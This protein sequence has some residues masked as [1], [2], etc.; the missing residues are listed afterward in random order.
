M[1][2]MLRRAQTTGQQSRWS[3]SGLNVIILQHAWRL[4]SN[5]SQAAWPNA[6]DGCTELIIFRDMT[7][8]ADYGK[9][10]GRCE[11]RQ[12]DLVDAGDLDQLPVGSGCRCRPAVVTML[13]HGRNERKAFMF[14]EVVSLLAQQPLGFLFLDRPS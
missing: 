11:T 10:Q 4:D 8:R 6:Y 2:N 12:R 14:V 1:L 7:I 3:N 9:K 13:R 5:C